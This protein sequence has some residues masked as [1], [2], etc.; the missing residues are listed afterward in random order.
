MIPIPVIPITNSPALGILDTILSI[1][2]IVLNIGLLNLA[3]KIKEAYHKPVQ[4]YKGFSKVLEDY[5][6]EDFDDLLGRET[7]I[8]IEEI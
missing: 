6:E 8:F 2:S 5:F 1:T 3:E 4:I 7:I